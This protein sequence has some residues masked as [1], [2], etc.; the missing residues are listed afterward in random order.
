MVMIQANITLL[1]TPHRTA[2]ARL[3]TPAPMIA[4]VMVWV[5]DT[6][7][8]AQLAAN[9]MIE[10]PVDAAKPWCCDNLVMRL[11]IVSMIFQP[12]INVPSPIAM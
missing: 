11:P 6:G 1:A 4:P 3:A 8:P 12:P 10:P 2:D 9:S 7:I 5:V